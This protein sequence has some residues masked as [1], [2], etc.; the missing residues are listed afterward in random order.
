MLAWV[1][2]ARIE[3]TVFI[4]YRRNSAN[5]VALLIYQNLTQ[6]GYDVFFDYKGIASGSFE[7]AI[8]ENIRAR[9]HFLVLLT[10][11]ALKRVDEPGDWLRREIETA[12]DAQRNIVP[13]LLDGFDFQTQYIA[14]LL[15]GK[16]ATLSEY[17][18][19]EVSEVYFEAA[20]QR[21]CDQ[22]LAKPLNA[23]VHPASSQAALAVRDL[24]ANIARSAHWRRSWRFVVAVV[25]SIASVIVVVGVMYSEFTARWRVASS[26]LT[27]RASAAENAVVAPISKPTTPD[28]TTIGRPSPTVA[29]PTSSASSELKS[30]PPTKTPHRGAAIASATKVNANSKTNSPTFSVAGAAPSASASNPDPNS[31][32]ISRI[33]E[34]VKRLDGGK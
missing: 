4:S 19:L 34:V 12:L 13:I 11:S 10:P 15:T 24:R 8:L 1:E 21:L 32:R 23:V 3:K 2:V 20:M 22:Y 31:L 33:R 27:S 25:A 14:R 16:L 18:G 5:W 6:K 30:I 17:N 9:A 26:S 28:G 29:P 7:L